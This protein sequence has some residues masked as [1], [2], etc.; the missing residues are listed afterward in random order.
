MTAFKF[1]NLSWRDGR[2]RWNP[3]ASTRALGFKSIDLKDRSGNWLAFKDACVQ[4]SKYNADVAR[5]R[6]EWRVQRG[7]P[8]KP[9][10][11]LDAPLTLSGYVY[12]LWV[13]GRV[14]IG[15]SERPLLRIDSMK[16]A[17][18]VQFDRVAIVKGTK[19]DERRLHKR[20]EVQH[21]KGEWF[22]ATARL[23]EL[24]VEMLTKGTTDI[25]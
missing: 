22:R 7:G 21:E 11:A 15:F 2:P 17:L 6:A 16:T 10:A 24:L 12:F 18:P 20:F 14:K 4:A 23:N 3:S 5:K 19:K 1:K 25:A 8:I 13:G 9:E